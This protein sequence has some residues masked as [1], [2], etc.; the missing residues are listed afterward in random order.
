[1]GNAF[2]VGVEHDLADIPGFRRFEHRDY[3]RMDGGLSPRE[4]HHFG[5][6]FRFHKVVQDTLYLL[7]REVEPRPGVGK[8]QR[9]VHVARAVNLDNAHTGMLLMFGAEAAV[10]RAAFDHVCTKCEGNTAWF[11]YPSGRDIGFGIGI[12]QRFEAAVRHEPTYV[13]ARLGL[14]SLLRRSGRLQESLSQYEQLIQTPR[15]ISG[16]LRQYFE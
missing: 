3:L 14:A 13:E 6:T 8:A 15:A 2:A 1:M 9:T 5:A 10:V 4:L 16:D 7:E 11:I 12:D